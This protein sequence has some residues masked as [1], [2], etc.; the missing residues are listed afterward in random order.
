MPA[1]PWLFENETDFKALPGKIATQ[2]RLGVPYPIMTKDEIEQ[3]AREQAL[4]IAETLKDSAFLPSREDLSGD[5]L[6]NYL[7]DRQVIAMIAYMQKLGAYTDS[8]LKKEKPDTFD[9]DQ[10]R[11]ARET[12]APVETAGR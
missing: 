8:G 4:A 3:N 10:Q 1:Y 6:R 9:P 12:P 7:A 11:Q 5:E 2:T